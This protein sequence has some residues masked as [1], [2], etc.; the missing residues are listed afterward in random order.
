M[1]IQVVV[2]IFLSAVAIAP[3]LQWRARNHKNCLIMYKQA[4]K[5][6]TIAVSLSVL[7]F[8]PFKSAYG[9]NYVY[10]TID[11]ARQ[12]DISE[13][14]SI[15]QFRTI[16]DYE[17]YLDSY[18]QGCLDKGSGGSASIPCHVKHR[19]WPRE[20]SLLYKKLFNAS[21]AKGKIALEEAHQAWRAYINRSREFTGQI[22]DKKFKSVQGTMYSLLAAGDADEMES[23]LLK[24][25]IQVLWSMTN[26]NLSINDYRN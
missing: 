15:S 25:R 2:V 12:L 11:G 23:L 1:I 4:C 16:D 5:I 26:L 3:I 21:D 9:F 24:Q 22:L 19:V 10:I 8:V 17:N 13:I 7:L 14:K 6:A 20:L 18:I